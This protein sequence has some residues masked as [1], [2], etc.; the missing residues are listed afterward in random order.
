MAGTFFMVIMLLVFSISPAEATV[1]IFEAKPQFLDGE[2]IPQAYGDRV[3]SSQQQVDSRLYYYGDAGGWTPNVVVDYGSEYGTNNFWSSGYGD[4]INVLENEHDG[5]NVITITF[6]A[7]PGYLVRLESFDLGGWPQTDR[8]VYAIT[9]TDGTNTLFYASNVLAK[10]QGHTTL[11]P[12]VQAQQLILTL[13]IRLGGDSDCV[14]I[15]NIKFSQSPP[16]PIPGTLALMG[17]GLLGLI[18]WRRFRK[19]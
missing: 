5:N 12:N 9:V 3:S 2:I 1:L 15:D 4:L 11:S 17:A 6:T 13:D 19:N 10:G 14:G 8:Y 18:S 7:D 16:V